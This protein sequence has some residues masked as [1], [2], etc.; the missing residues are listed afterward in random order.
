MAAEIRVIDTGLRSGRENI[1]HDAA[2]ITGGGAIYMDQ[3]QLGWGL[4]CDKNL[5]P[6]SNLPDIT[7][8]ICEA[9]ALGLSSLGFDAKFRPRN[10]I[11]VN[12]KKISGTGGYFEGNTLIFQGTIII[13]T[14]ME[15][16][17][18]VLNVPLHKLSKREIAA[19][20]ERVTSL[21][22][23]LGEAPS[24]EVVKSAL[25]KGFEDHLG[26]KMTPGEANAQ[27]EL[28]AL[29][30]LQ[31]DIGTEEF[32]AEINDPG[33]N[34]DVM[35]GTNGGGNLKAFV[36]LEGPKSNRVREVLFTG[37]IFITPPR[38][39]NDLENHLRGVT[40]DKV[41]ASIEQFFEDTEIGLVSL[42]PS[43]FTDAILSAAS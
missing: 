8:T 1:A 37:D 11:E 6:G 31:E 14:D 38:T 32:V 16:M 19:I 10:D 28:L 43:E 7:R 12:G 39:L 41:S 34:R 29:N 21:K 22:K 3:G 9:I 4:V 35:V 20:T 26:F 23:L 27:E 13:D 36:R 5:F 18:S 25:L 30:Y 33:R 15:A 42:Q 2:M 17:M 24:K 40:V